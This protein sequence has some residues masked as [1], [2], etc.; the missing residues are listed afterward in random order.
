M[1]TDRP[2]VYGLDI[3][4]DTAAGGLDPRRAGI[5]AIAVVTAARDI[6][7]TG[8]ESEILADVDEAIR[9][10][11]PGVIATWNGSAFDLPFIIDRAAKHGVRLGLAINP[12]STLATRTPLPGHAGSYRGTWF[13]H[14]HLDAYRLYRNDLK[15]SLDVSCS[16]KSVAQL[17]GIP[18]VDAD[19]S[20]VHEL[21]EAELRRYVASDARVARQLA[22]KRWTTAS[23]FVDG[24]S[25]TLDVA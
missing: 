20:R 9:S 13:E 11:D 23:R 16:L 18:F 6:V 8:S 21:E 4:T 3:E 2:P 22:L 25:V 14:H 7:F 5:L 17:T 10:L 1:T 15:R 24:A 19:A 12:D